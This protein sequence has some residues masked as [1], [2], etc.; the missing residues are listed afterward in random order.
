RMVIESGSPKL[1]FEEPQS[2][3]DGSVYWLR[4]SKVPLRDINDEII[5]ILGSYE[6]ITQKKQDEDS[7]R[8]LSDAVNSSISSIVMTDLDGKIIYVNPAFLVQWG[9]RNM[10]ELI[11]YPLAQLMA[12]ETLFNN[13]WLQLR[14]DQNWE[15]ELSGVK[16]VGGHFDLSVSATMVLDDQAN[17]TRVI[18]FMD[19]ITQRKRMEEAL[20]QNEKKN[21][22]L[23][24]SLPDIIIR[25]TSDGTILDFQDSNENPLFD[26]NQMLGKNITEIIPAS[27]SELVL[28]LIAKALDTL[29]TQTVEYKAKVN[30]HHNYFDTR[31]IAMDQNEVLIIARNITE[32][33]TIDEKLK[34]QALIFETMYDGIILTGL[35]GVI[36]DWNRGA[37][38]LYGYSKEEVIG[39]N[40]SILYRK[41]N[42][43][44]VSSEILN[45][46]KTTGQWTGEVK[47]ITKDNAMGI[48][49]TIVVPMRDERGNIVATLG[50]NRDITN[51]KLIERELQEKVQELEDFN[52]VAVGRE[53]RMIEIK[54]EI[55]QLL[56]ESGK[57]EKYEIVN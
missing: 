27:S 33:K 41:E 14:K 15:G 54:K 10:D 31:L 49:E 55:N 7:L 18:A 28:G 16:K 45:D 24:S 22:T 9:I 8:V 34:Q 3:R 4:T 23:I 42:A 57:K 43:G 56:K 47:Y 6:D 44:A 1:D 11:N 51:R 35:D 37:E 20:V 48:S 17:P 12:D 19:D 13:M 25:I 52:R 5:G 50:V 21:R 40:I 26:S 32:R 46:I 29:E 38:R 30:D 36:I 53:L 2:K 39:K